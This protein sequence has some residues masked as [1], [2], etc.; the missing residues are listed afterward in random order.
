[1]LLTEIL[2]IGLSLSMDAFAVAACKGAC[3]RKISV[4]QSLMLAAF[5]GFFQA[6][7]PVFGWLLGSRFQAYIE[8][9]DHWIAFFLLAY[10][11]GKMIRDVFKGENE[12]D[13]CRLLTVREA[14]V[15]AV[16]TSIDALAVGIVLAIERVRILFPAALIGV[17]TFVI[18]LLGAVLGNKFGAHFKDKAQVAGG[19]ALIGIGFKILLEHLNLL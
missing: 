7:M 12:E 14:L 13:A 17:E 18:S 1:M 19:V 2:L 3:M 9:Y 8:R 5:F 10:I 4:K 11:G 16:A 15:L 6:T